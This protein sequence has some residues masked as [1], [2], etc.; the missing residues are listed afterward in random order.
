MK[1][2]DPKHI[3]NPSFC[4]IQEKYGMVRPFPRLQTRSGPRV[5]LFPVNVVF[6][7]K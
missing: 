4:F 1:L 2:S 6:I 7:C 5:L 3:L